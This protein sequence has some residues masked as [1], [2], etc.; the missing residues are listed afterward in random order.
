MKLSESQLRVITN[1]EWLSKVEIEKIKRNIEIKN[2]SDIDMDQSVKD[3]DGDRGIELDVAAYVDIMIDKR[4]ER[5]DLDENAK[6]IPL[7]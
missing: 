4:V 2:N 3:A 7:I 6:K 1:N 5:D